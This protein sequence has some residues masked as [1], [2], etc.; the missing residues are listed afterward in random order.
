MINEGTTKGTQI[1]TSYF[2]I[3]SQ[4]FV[5]NKTLTLID[6]QNLVYMLKRYEYDYVFIELKIINLNEALLFFV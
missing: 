1:I 5:K 2:G 3:D 4:N 6:G